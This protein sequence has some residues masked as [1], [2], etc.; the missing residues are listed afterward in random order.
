MNLDSIIYQ[1]YNCVGFESISVGNDVET[2]T[3][4][5]R[6]KIANIRIEANAASTV[7][8]RFREDGQDPTAADGMPLYNTEV[9]SIRP[10]C[11]ATFKMIS[12]DAANT[13]KVN[14][15]YYG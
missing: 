9:Y 1:A 5:D 7:P 2:L 14:I 6:A 11:L 10:G 15:S 12:G 8:I 13:Q 4:P 3:I